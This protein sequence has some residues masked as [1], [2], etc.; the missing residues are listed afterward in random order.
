MAYNEEVYNDKQI[1]CGRLNG[2]KSMP[3]NEKTGTQNWYIKRARG[4]TR[5]N[6][7]EL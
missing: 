2:L 7:C 5:A 4:K 1:Y 6:A 3:E